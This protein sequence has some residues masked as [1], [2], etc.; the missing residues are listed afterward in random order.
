VA[1]RPLLAYL[2]SSS[3]IVNDPFAVQHNFS[4]EPPRGAYLG[5]KNGNRDLVSRLQCRFRPAILVFTNDRRVRCGSPIYD[6]AFCVPHVIH[7]GDMRIP[8]SELCHCAFQG[9]HFVCVVRHDGTVVCE[10]QPGRRQKRRSQTN[11]DKEFISNANLPSDCR[12]YTPET[13]PSKA[14]DACA[15]PHFISFLIR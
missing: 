8:P 1:A 15:D 9:D 2:R 5:G 7:D 3:R 6:V 14:D 4:Q 13:L 12:T 10:R 11:I